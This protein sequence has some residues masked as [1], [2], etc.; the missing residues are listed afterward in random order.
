[1]NKEEKIE[2][3]KRGIFHKVVNVFLYF[4]LVIFVVVLIAVGITQTATFRDWLR[5]TIVEEVNASIN[6]KINITKI[7]GTFFTSLL[8]REGS[9]EFG[10]DTIVSFRRIAA[11]I[12]PLKIFFKEIS[13]REVELNDV[14][15]RFLK[16]SLGVLNITKVF[17]PSEE[18]TSKSEFPFGINV[19]SLKLNNVNFSLQSDEKKNS[20]EV[21]NNINF[22]DFRISNLNLA[23]TAHANINE[24]IFETNISNLSFTSNISNFNLEHLSGNFSLTP[25]EI[26]IS[27]FSL[28]TNR[29]DLYLNLKSKDLNIFEDITKKV[30]QNSYAK[31]EL[32]ANKFNFDDLTAF[33]P[34]TNILKGEVST[35]ISVEGN[36]GDLT[37]EN[38]KLNYLE[39][40]LDC[41][42][43]LQNLHDP[44]RLYITA[45]FR[46]SQINYKDA[47]KLLPGLT[48]P[49]FNEFGIVKID[50][51]NYEGEPINFKSSFVLQIADASINGNSKLDFRETDMKYTVLLKTSNLNLQNFINIPS[52]LNLKAEIEGIGSSISSINTRIN[53]D[54][55]NSSIG[56]TIID[57]LTLASDF[58]NSILDLYTS[59][60]IKDSSS[61]DLKLNVDFTDENNPKYRFNSNFVQI[62]LGK[63]FSDSLLES[64]INL[65]LNGEGENFNPELINGNLSLNLF[66]SLFNELFVKRIDCNLKLNA[67]EKGNKSINLQSTLADIY[68]SGNFNYASVG[69]IV[70]KEIEKIKQPIIDKI[71]SYLSGV[72]DTNEIE[73]LSTSDFNKKEDTLSSYF[74]IAFNIHSKNL[75]AL[76]FF[77][78]NYDI[79]AA[80]IIDGEIKNNINGFSF[81]T[82]LNFDLIKLWSDSVV[83][84][85]SDAAFRLGVSHMAEKYMLEDIK[86][87]TSANI[88]LLYLNKEIKKIVF[89]LSLENNKLLLYTSANYNNLIK[90]KVQFA[91]DLTSPIFKLD[92]DKLKMDYNNFEI[93]SRNKILIGYLND[94][95]EIKNFNLYRGDA[96]ILMNG[97]IA[98]EGSQD[99]SIS[100]KNFRGYDLSYSLLNISPENVIDN[101]LQLLASIKGTFDNP[102]ISLSLKVDSINYK[103]RKFGSLICKADY[104]SKELIPRIEFWDINSTEI[105]RFNL[106]GKVP[107]D[108]TFSSVENRLP[109]NKEVDLTI[110]SQEFDLAALGDALPFIDRLKGLFSADIKITG[111]YDNLYRKGIVAFRNTTFIAE[112]NNLEYGAGIILRLDDQ[113]LYVDSMVVANIAGVKNKGQMRGRGKVEFDGLSL[114]S[115]QFLLNGDLTVLTDESRT[116]TQSVYGNLYIA[117]QGDIIYA[118]NRDKS[119][120]KANIVVNQMN[121]V[122]PP[123]E[124]GYSSTYE[125]FIY[126]YV[127]D[128]SRISKKQ[129]EIE[130]LIAISESRN[131]RAESTAKIPGGF[132]YD[133]RV[134]IRDDARITFVL[135]KEANQKLIAD[136]KGELEYSRIN[137]IP[138]VQGELKL[139]EG[140]T[141]DFIKSFG[142]SGSIVFESD[143]TNPNLD[144]TAMYKNTYS[145]PSD[146]NN[147]E[148]VA[149]KI[150]L[151]GRLKELSKVFAKME[152]NIAI[153]RGTQNIQNNI[154]ETSLEKADALWFILTGKFT[155]DMGS[156]EKFDFN[157]G[158]TAT[159]FAG[160]LLGGLLNTYLGDYVRNFELQ[161]GTTTKFNISGNINRLK[162]TFGGTTN[163]FQDISHA[164]I[165]LEYPLI[166]NLV[167]RFER[168]EPLTESSYSGEMTN[169]LGLKYRFEF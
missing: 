62:D 43:T 150:K 3:K 51:L 107:I 23:L 151:K 153:Y 61:I 18:D 78:K 19:S 42:G 21:Y 47:E 81:N 116:A 162:Y 31:V 138:S 57:N 83:Y 127:L 2:K 114:V 140:S 66:N 122:F 96:E 105:P 110:I 132:D 35:Y 5:D 155:K 59:S 1:L 44:S 161:S 27:G 20:N 121:L 117:T 64:N 79:Q 46:N 125:N 8:I 118:S 152:D 164:N 74:D 9:L 109:K 28:I 147:E 156:S 87:Y 95:L 90:G 56:K 142:A 167:I 86:F 6:G 165:R 158:G 67:D 85:V 134:K 139:L 38:L 52:S 99:F 111:T 168:R 72:I 104:N 145:Q 34:A 163:T 126:K 88:D 68:V 41:R 129:T 14:S 136:L 4:F 103:G 115:T 108:L 143:L 159:S 7:D 89:D 16:D 65:S 73:Q 71:N 58:K 54:I 39:T 45:N 130:K 22:E 49:G 120:L 97:I 91:T 13:I 60:V 101:N 30:L 29:T 100:I 33:V 128:T 24:N 141:L 11:K 55:S 102:Q 84:F 135:A 75:S 123:T 53:L 10:S 149:V 15:I 94:K 32:N 131:K 77:L 112:P 93:Q 133:I 17:P 154:A 48:L 80:G 106:F 124:S 157:V 40:L 37:I 92:I 70:S 144:I 82:D 113:T 166:E 137:E 98:K 160:S 25:N 169:E 69:Q 119:L 12:N 36:I 148:E 76:S 26:V 63:I 146:E 50:T